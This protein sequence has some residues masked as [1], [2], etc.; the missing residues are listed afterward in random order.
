MDVVAPLAVGTDIEHL[1]EPELLRPVH[2]QIAADEHD[3]APLDWPFLHVRTEVGVLDVVEAE[4][5][6]LF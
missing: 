5:L 3:D 4:G 6:D 2:A 1:G